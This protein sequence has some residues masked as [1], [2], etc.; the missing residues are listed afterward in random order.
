MAQRRTLGRMAG[1]GSD[2]KIPYILSDGSVA[3]DNNMIATKGWQLKA[4]LLN[5]VVLLGHDVN[6]FPIGRGV[7]IRIEGDQLLGAIDY[8]PADLNPVGDC[9]FRMVKGGF[10][11][12]VSVSWNPLTW[13]YS[14]DRSRQGGIDF[15]TQELLEFSQ[16]VVPALA[17][18]LATA[19]S[20][21]IDTRPIFAW[22]EHALDL[23]RNVGVSRA[24]LEAA[25]RAA[26]MPAH[27]PARRAPLVTGFEPTPANR[28]AAARQRAYQNCKDYGSDVPAAFRPPVTRHERECVATGAMLRANASTVDFLRAES[29][30]DRRSR[31]RRRCYEACRTDGARVPEFAL[32]PVS[33][34]EREA[35]TLGA[36]IRMRRGDP[37]PAVA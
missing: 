23:G 17:T 7:D 22:A 19:R 6:S 37:I 29:S 9:C 8:T 28:S 18:A 3:R 31:L 24:E 25:R 14:T 4:Y 36:N 27:A 5:N 10:M 12:A 26:R 32:P 15:L 11:H 30:D 1:T 2:R 20:A 34:W 21:G 35:L 16:V 33:P 13:K